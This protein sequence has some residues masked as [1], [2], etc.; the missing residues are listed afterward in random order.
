MLVEL[1]PYQVAFCQAKIEAAVVTVCA[2][3]IENHITRQLDL[4][5]N[6]AKQRWALTAAKTGAA[7][8][9]WP[10]T[11]VLLP[12]EVRLSDEIRTPYQLDQFQVGGTGTEWRA[13]WR[14]RPA[15]PEG[16]T[17]LTVHVTAGGTTF[18]SRAN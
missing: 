3:V 11:A 15:P 2:R 1:G 9:E 16:V 8:P 14:F 18:H 5:H 17:D 6:L 4:D 10:A 12:L 7:P 13:C